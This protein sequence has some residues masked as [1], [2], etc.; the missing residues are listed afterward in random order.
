MKIHAHER[1]YRLIEETWVH[2]AKRTTVSC[3]YE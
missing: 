2:K 3:Q 1:G